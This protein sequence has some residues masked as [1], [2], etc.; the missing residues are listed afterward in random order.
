MSVEFEVQVLVG[1]DVEVDDFEDVFGGDDEFALDL[2]VCVC[3]VLFIEVDLHL[4]YC[5]GQSTKLKVG[6]FLPAC[7][8]SQL[9]LFFETEL[10]K[11]VVVE[12][13]DGGGCFGEDA[14]GLHG[15]V[16]EVG[17]DVVVALKL[18][19]EFGLEV[20]EV[21]PEV[22]SGLL[23]GLHL[24]ALVG[25][26]VVH[27]AGADGFT[28]EGAVEGEWNVVVHAPRLLP[29]LR[30]ALDEGHLRLDILLEGRLHRLYPRIV[31]GSR[32][33][34]LEPHSLRLRE[35][36]LR[37]RSRL[38]HFTIKQPILYRIIVCFH[39]LTSHHPTAHQSP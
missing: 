34:R 10:F 13:V 21:F 14:A 27:A 39:S 30:Q 25:A 3:F 2:G 37:R 9:F 33:P 5:P 19:F 23:E 32:L 26:E 22:L 15:T 29:L 31:L 12:A 20:V 17:G 28:A 11:E 8:E 16:V 7:E 24:V 4:G 35:G 1:V 6:F 36:R 38:H 18:G